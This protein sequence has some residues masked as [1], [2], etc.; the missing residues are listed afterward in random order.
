MSLIFEA[1][2][3][4]WRRVRADFDLFVESQLDAAELACNG[5]LLNDRG[6]AAGVSYRSLFAGPGSH[7]RAR[8]YA[9]EELREFWSH[10]PRMTFASF[11]GQVY[12]WAEDL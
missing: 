12:E 10:T 5:N 1:A 3:D 9:S 11:E 8:A 4:E 7:M 2:L 6:R